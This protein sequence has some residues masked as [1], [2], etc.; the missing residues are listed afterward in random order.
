MEMKKNILK[1]LIFCFTFLFLAGIPQPKNANA[2]GDPIC[3]PGS[4]EIR[5]IMPVPFYEFSICRDKD[6]ATNKCC[7]QGTNLPGYTFCAYNV[8]GASTSVFDI[9]SNLP[10]NFSKYK[11]KSCQDLLNHVAVSDKNYC[12][13]NNQNFFTYDPAG[14]SGRG[15]CVIAGVKDTFT[16]IGGS[17]ETAVGTVPVG[18]DLNGFLTF[19]LRL[20]FFASGGVILLMIISTGYTIITSSGDPEKL[21][22]ARENIIALFSGLALIAFS[23]VLLQ[24]IGADILGIPGFK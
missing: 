23:L 4:I 1:L 5:S 24:T 13:P 2:V 18:P 8:P 3:I 20:A 16:C 14:N 9:Y 6:I 11:V 10:I 12:P 19:A 15:A 7:V 22:A 17:C 21:Q